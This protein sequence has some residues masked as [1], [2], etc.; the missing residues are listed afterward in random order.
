MSSSWAACRPCARSAAVV[1]FDQV[2]LPDGGHGLQLGQIARAACVSPSCPMPAPTAP[3]VTRA[4][5]RPVAISW[6]SSSARAATRCLVQ[7][8]AGAGQHARADF[9]DHGVGGGGNFLTQQIGHR[10]HARQQNEIVSGDAR[11][12]R[13][14]ARGCIIPCWHAMAK[15]PLFRRERL[16]AI[17]RGFAPTVPVVNRAW[18]FY[19]D[20]GGR[21]ASDTGLRGDFCANCVA[22]SERAML[23]ADVL[24]LALRTVSDV[25]PTDA[26]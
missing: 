12:R 20:V 17:A 2:A 15:T 4:T 13:D 16:A 19:N 6:C 11:E 26:T 3:E 14:T 23:R 7:Q 21:Q 1:G 25:W 9:D 24:R 10:P 22:E 5:L 18:R 8:P